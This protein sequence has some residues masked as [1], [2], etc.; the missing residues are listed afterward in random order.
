MIF[1][2]F[3]TSC[4]LYKSEGQ[5]KFE[6]AGKE[7]LVT[8]EFKPIQCDEIT[9]VSYWYETRFS[10]ARSQWIESLPNFEIWQDNLGPQQIQIRTY[11]RH[12]EPQQLPSVTR[13]QSTFSSLQEWTKFRN[14]YVKSLEGEQP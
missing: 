9:M 10:S 13:C 4:S 1:A 12:T 3:I 8:Q 6:T 11:E 5:K 7:N 2:L 14:F